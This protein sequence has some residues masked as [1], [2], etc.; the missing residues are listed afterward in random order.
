[1]R[2]SLMFNA[3]WAIWQLYHGLKLHFDEM[4]MMMST[5]YK[6]NTL[7][8]IFIVLPHQWNYSAWVDMSLH[9]DT[10]FWFRANQ[11]FLLLFS[12]VCLAVKQQIIYGSHRN[13]KLDL[14]SGV[15]S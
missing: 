6:T 9:S 11:R 8:W 13:K 15:K 4:I 12:D 14:N 3:K 1:M 2:E 10:L 5:L 7:S